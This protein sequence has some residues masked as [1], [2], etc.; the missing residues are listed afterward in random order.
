MG[1]PALTLPRRTLPRVAPQSAP[2]RP[3]GDPPREGAAGPSTVAP[4]CGHLPAAARRANSVNL[5]HM[6]HRRKAR[7]SSDAGQR[8]EQIGGDAFLDEAAAVADRQY[9]SVVMARAPARDE[10]IQRF[11]AMDLPPL[12]QRCQRPVDCWGRD[13]WVGRK[14]LPKDVVGGQGST[15][16]AQD[17]EHLRLRLLSSFAHRPSPVDHMALC[18]LCYNVTQRA[19][20][21]PKSGMR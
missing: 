9:G 17:R 15:M 16:P 8:P 12:R 4:S 6:A 7:S 14:Q 1:P 19:S 2:R 3:T 21:D 10:S 11:K 18:T 5:D 13:F 20:R